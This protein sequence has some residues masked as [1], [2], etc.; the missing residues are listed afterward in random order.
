MTHALEKGWDI[1]H[2]SHAIF[3]TL[4]KFLHFLPAGIKLAVVSNFDTRLRAIL[5]KL[6]LL[7]LFDSVI[8]SAEVKAEKPNPVIFEQ[9]CAQLGVSPSQSLV[10][11]DDR[12]SV[13]SLPLQ[14]SKHA[15]SPFMYPNTCFWGWRAIKE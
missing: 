9:A 5:Q 14:S 10:L 1:Q 8:I 7:S 15:W 2:R 11:G 3:A 4:Y 13:L 12:R 6:G